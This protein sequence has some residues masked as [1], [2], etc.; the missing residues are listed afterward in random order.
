M[1]PRART[2]CLKYR[3]DR[4]RRK[5][6][7]IPPD[8]GL[9][10]MPHTQR[11]RPAT[12]GHPHPIPGAPGS[13]QWVSDPGP[14]APTRDGPRQKAAAPPPSRLCRSGYRRRSGTTPSRFLQTSF[15]AHGSSRPAFWAA[16]RPERTLATSL[17][18][19][20]SCRL[21]PAS[22]RRSRPGRRKACRTTDYRRR[23]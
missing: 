3:E 17:R 20:P 11:K 5:N 21:P 1:I 18:K 12:A 19:T 6:G 15:Q 2:R 4:S 7:R 14:S 23:P 13:G 9:F 8:S 16:Q 22:A 10:S